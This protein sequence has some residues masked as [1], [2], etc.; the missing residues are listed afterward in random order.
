MN[1]SVLPKLA[2]GLYLSLKPVS[3]FLLLCIVIKYLL[4]QNVKHPVLI[5][6]STE[7]EAEAISVF[8]ERCYLTL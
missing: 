5:S 4:S 2:T 7:R 8:A 1:P 3:V 6:H